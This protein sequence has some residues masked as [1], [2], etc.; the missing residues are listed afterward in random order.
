MA[1]LFINQW[2]HQ[3]IIS[4][5]IRRFH[6]LSLSIWQVLY[7]LLTRPPWYP[8]PEGSLLIDL[9]VLSILS[10]FIL[11][12]D[13]TLHSIFISTTFNLFFLGVCFFFYFHCPFCQRIFVVDKEY[14]IKSHWLCQR[15]FSIFLCFFRLSS[16]TLYFQGFF[17]DNF[18]EIYDLQYRFFTADTINYLKNFCI[19]KIL[20]IFIW[21]FRSE[22]QCSI[23]FIFW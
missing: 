16:Q 17:L 8:L 3:F 1:L 10:A 18:F 11:S 12:Q 15:F 5:L 6:R 21:F 4:G 13:Q 14:I 19:L 23:S 2:C 9:H 20:I 22:N 7:A